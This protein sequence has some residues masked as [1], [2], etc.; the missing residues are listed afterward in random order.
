MEYKELY[1]RKGNVGYDNR[2]T[3]Y[4]VQENQKAKGFIWAAKTLEDAKQ[5]IDEYGD[6]LRA[7]V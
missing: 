2:I 6:K 4:F 5:L 1:I 7:I 3:M